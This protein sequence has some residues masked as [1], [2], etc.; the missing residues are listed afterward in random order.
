MKVLVY[1]TVYWMNMNYWIIKIIVVKLLIW[2][3]IIYAQSSSFSL[4][5]QCFKSSKNQDLYLY[6]GNF[7]KYPLLH[8]IRRW[9]CK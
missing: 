5:F 6:T 7:N 4:L 8:L 3:Q 1:N 2:N 9:N